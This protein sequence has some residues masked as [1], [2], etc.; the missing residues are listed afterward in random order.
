MNNQ[1]LPTDLVV[2]IRPLFGPLSLRA[3]LILGNM[4]IIIIAVAATGY[5]VYSRSSQSN[6]YLSNQLDT[7]VAQQAQEKLNNTSVSQATALNNFFVLMG[8]DITTI[9]A[10]ASNLLSQETTLN[11][12]AFWDGSTALARLANGS[13]DNSKTEPSSVFIPSKQDLSPDLVAELNTLKQ[14]DLTAP[15]ILKQNP[16]TVAI[17]FGGKSGETIYYPNI[18]LA[19]VVPPD[20]DVTSR[21]WYI[22]ASPVQ[23]PG[24]KSVWSD[25]YLDAAL[26]GLVVTT[27]IPVVDSGGN[28]VALP[29]WIFNSIE[30]RIWYPTSRL[31]RPVML[32]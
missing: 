6:V 16:D 8:R 1:P 27:S 32:F 10:N 15:T 23:N 22:N 9:G 25:P 18:D 31:E 29:Q 14:L 17:Y 26:H 20:F 7:N 21:P 13:W 19:S 5:Y 2:K 11:N 30:F 28:S 24:K 4:L 3:K 12:T